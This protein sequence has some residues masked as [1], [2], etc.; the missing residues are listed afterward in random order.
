VQIGRYDV[1][2]GERALT[3]TVRNPNGLRVGALVFVGA[4]LGIFAAS[5]FLPPTA[6]CMALLL[7][8]VVGIVVS[9]VWGDRLAAAGV[10]PRIAR[11]LEVRPRDGAGYREGAGMEL[12]IDGVSFDA[13]RARTLTVRTIDNGRGRAI[14]NLYL[15]LDDRAFL[16]ETSMLE[17]PIRDLGSELEEVLEVDIPDDDGE[18]EPARPL[19]VV[20]VATMMLAELAAMAPAMVLV[21]NGPHDMPLPPI[22][23][24][25]STLDVV[26]ATFVFALLYRPACRW[27]VKKRA[28]D[29]FGW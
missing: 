11:S 23:A 9:A 29:M 6:T 5:S 22:A 15:A 16:V 13:T 14:M 7:L 8:G 10:L 17:K 24:L 19:T 2:R 27:L 3:L 26:G 18:P 28:A 12:V 25:T 20:I 4:A 1:V 21:V